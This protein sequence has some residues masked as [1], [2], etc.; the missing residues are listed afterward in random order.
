MACAP[1]FR[2]IRADEELFRFPGVGINV[3]FLSSILA[4]VKKIDFK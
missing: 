4:I 1:E 2:F 3:P